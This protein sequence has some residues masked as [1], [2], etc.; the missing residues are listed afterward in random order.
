MLA[1][2]LYDKRAFTGCKRQR[3]SLRANSHRLHFAVLINRV[4][5][6]S[7]LEGKTQRLFVAY[8][9]V[10]DRHERFVTVRVFH[11]ADNM[12]TTR[13]CNGREGRS[14]ACRK[15]ILREQAFVF[16]FLIRL[17]LS[18]RADS[19]ETTVGR[20]HNNALP[21]IILVKRTE[22]CKLV[23]D[24]LD[25]VIHFRRRTI[26]VQC[27]VR[28]DAQRIVRPPRN[29]IRAKGKRRIELQSQ[30]FFRRRFVIRRTVAT[31][32]KTTTLQYSVHYRVS[33]YCIRLQNSQVVQESISHGPVCFNR[34]GINRQIFAIGK[35]TKH[36]IAIRLNIICVRSII[37]VFEI[38]IGR[39]KVDHERSITFRR[40][41]SLNIPIRIFCYGI[42]RSRRR[43]GFVPRKETCKAF[44]IREI[45]QR[46]K[47]VFL[48]VRPVPRPYNRFYTV[49]IEHIDDILRNGDI[50]CTGKLDAVRTTTKQYRRKA[51]VLHCLRNRVIMR[52]IIVIGRVQFGMIPSH[53]IVYGRTLYRVIE[54]ENVVFVRVNPA[55]NLRRRSNLETADFFRRKVN[56][57]VQRRNHRFRFHR[58]LT[59]N[60]RYVVYCIFSIIGCPQ[61]IYIR[62]EC[63]DIFFLYR[64][65]VV[66]T[67]N[68]LLRNVI[69]R[70]RVVFNIVRIVARHRIL[71][72]EF[73]VRKTNEFT[74]KIVR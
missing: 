44:A 3:I 17:V 10:I 30:L 8:R 71:R 20:A 31:V 47:R 56:F 46:L 23:I 39:Q 21:I 66:F 59:V 40:A 67:F 52:V 50:L 16:Y 27:T 65:C 32:L 6:K 69:D 5:P 18:V 42:H 73:Y 15:Q 25:I 70:T 37:P 4:L 26:C 41:I 68:C 58:T 74:R 54:I 9:S 61:F 12:V 43:L 57:A 28:Y 48:R 53:S 49:A 35:F 72:T 63:V 2:R 34:V 1:I 62:G 13:T 19:E 33:F 7:P 22:R 29:R 55:R 51:C 14:V 64:A 45:G 24:R 60:C 36:D 11:N 38:G